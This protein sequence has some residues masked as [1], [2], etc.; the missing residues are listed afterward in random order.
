MGWVRVRVSSF[1][2]CSNMKPPNSPIAR[3]FT[4]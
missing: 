2:I 1:K 3:A 4:K